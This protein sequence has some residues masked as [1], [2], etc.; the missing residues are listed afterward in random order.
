MTVLARFS[1]RVAQRTSTPWLQASE[2]EIAAASKPM[3]AYCGHYR[4]WKQD[5]TTLLATK[6]EM[7]LDPNMIGTN[8]VRQV[9]L[10]AC[11]P[12]LQLTLMV[13]DEHKETTMA[14]I[15]PPYS[16][17]LKPCLVT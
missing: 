9:D 6:V 2:G 15:N 14:V 7:A 17:L 4:T 12:Q 11:G 10:K 3:A 13:N 5:G 16:L 1:A 8:Q